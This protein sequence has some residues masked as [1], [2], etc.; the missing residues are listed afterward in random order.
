MVPPP[1]HKMDAF[2]SLPFKNVSLLYRMT[3]K[4]H[5]VVNKAKYRAHTNKYLLTLHVQKLDHDKE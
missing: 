3:D 1:V 5:K 2:V 4:Y